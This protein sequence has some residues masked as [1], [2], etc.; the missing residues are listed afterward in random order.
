MLCRYVLIN[1]IKWLSLENITMTVSYGGVIWYSLLNSKQYILVPRKKLPLVRGLV[2]LE[3]FKFLNIFKQKRETVLMSFSVFLNWFV[4][5]N[6]TMFNGEF[7][8]T[9][10]HCCYT[11]MRRWLCNTNKNHGIG[12]KQHTFF[13]LL[14][15]Y[16]QQSN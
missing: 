5:Q 12:F 8:F 15:Y 13:S 14:V 2:Y 1:D 16:S 9:V 6:H 10:L 7:K 3:D 4:F 11:H